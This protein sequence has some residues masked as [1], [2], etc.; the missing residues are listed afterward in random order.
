MH[1]TFRAR[2]GVIV[3]ASGNPGAS[4]RDAYLATGTG[5][6]YRTNSAP[7]ILLNQKTLLKTARPYR[8]ADG[9]AL[10]FCPAPTGTILQTS[11]RPHHPCFH[12]NTPLFCVTD[13]KFFRLCSAPPR[14]QRLCVSLCSL[15]FRL[16]PAATPLPRFTKAVP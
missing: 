2:L 6:T 14:S 12:A 4:L 8:P 15:D 3:L 13:P 5:C 11:P 1:E 10:S 7:A 16:S 9:T